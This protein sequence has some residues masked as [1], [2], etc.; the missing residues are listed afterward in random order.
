MGKD[1]ALLDQC[2]YLLFDAPGRKWRET[3]D[4][5]IKTTKPSLLQ[6]TTEDNVA[7][8]IRFSSLAG[9]CISGVETNGKKIKKK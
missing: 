6:E 3:F 9:G 2:D 8:A 1:A 5:H 4:W 7:D